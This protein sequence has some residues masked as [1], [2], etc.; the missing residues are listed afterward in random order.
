MPTSDVRKNTKTTR[1]LTE[2]HW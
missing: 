2:T 1:T